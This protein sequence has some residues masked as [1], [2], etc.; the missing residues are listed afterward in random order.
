[1]KCEMHSNVSILTIQVR[2][3]DVLPNGTLFLCLGYITVVELREV[4]SRLNYHVSERRLSDVLREID[5]D[6]DGKI[7]YEEFV[8]MI[9]DT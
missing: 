9:Q 6:H 7:S 8:C 3:V 4:L 2:T 1:M 5:T